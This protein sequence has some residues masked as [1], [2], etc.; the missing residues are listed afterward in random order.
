MSRDGRSKKLNSIVDKLAVILF[1]YPFVALFISWVLPEAFHIFDI[2]GPYSNFAL[3]AP[4]ILFLP[5][6]IR[7]SEKAPQSPFW[8]R[9]HTDYRFKAKVAVGVSLI[10]I[11]LGTIA[12]LL[13]R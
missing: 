11:V 8:V 13:R 2:F 12:L 7:I 6:L 4:F 1:V 10:V 3:A 5:A 9:V